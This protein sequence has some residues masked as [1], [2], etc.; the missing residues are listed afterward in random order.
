[1]KD[2]IGL[3][4][5]EIESVITGMGFKQ[6]H[7]LTIVN[8]MYKRRITDLSLIP[9][10]PV[11]LRNNLIN[12]NS[13]AVNGPVSRIASADGTVKYLFRTADKKEFETVYI[14]DGKR[15]T[16]C[17][18]TQSGCRMGCK[19]CATAQYGF[20]GNLNT[21]EIISQVLRI[22]ESAIIDHIVFMGMGEPMDN[23][24]NVLKACQIMT[25]ERGMALGHKNVTVSSVG[26]APGI[27]TF[28]EN[29]KCNFTLS[30]HSP[31]PEERAGIMPVE[32]KYPVQN[33]IEMLKSLPIKRDR[34]ITLAYVMI[35]GWNDTDTHLR[36]LTGLVKGSSLR[37]NLLPFH[38][39]PGSGTES[40]TADRM[41]YF[42]HVLVCQGV[43]ASVR[44][45]RGAD[46]SAACGLL[47]AS[48]KSN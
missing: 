48:S 25:T 8:Y 46:I 24:D 47:A 17:V 34:R 9:G 14:P 3:T 19:Y 29:T 13:S 28:L 30:L 31:F 41:Q 1:M 33:I 23:I 21:G 22:K 26:L 43:S 35:K 39:I 38:S 40:S 18:S 44:K 16:V 12:E 4:Y 36:A 32:K 6:T 37:I 10:L 2:L 5:S 11:S 27:K 45:S 7:A 42:K 20:H 15:N